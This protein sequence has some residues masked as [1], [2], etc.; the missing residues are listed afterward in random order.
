MKTTAKIPFIR[1]IQKI[2]GGTALAV[3]LA[4]PGG[5]M[6]EEFVIPLGDMGG[7]PLI[8]VYIGD[9]GPYTMIFDTGAPLFLKSFL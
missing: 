9:N 7:R 4:I 6:A 5:A 1:T 8:D 3:L 2:L